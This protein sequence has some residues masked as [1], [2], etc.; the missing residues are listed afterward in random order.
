MT[1]TP[2]VLGLDLDGV[3]AD[4]T[5]GFRSYVAGV[6]G[7]PAEHLPDPVDWDWTRCGW[8]IGSR[9]EYLDLHAGAVDAGLF[10]D[11][12]PLPGVSEALWR[13][14]DAGVRV[15]V[16]TH[17]LI[18]SGSHAASAADTV[19]WL[20]RHRIPYWDLCFM[21]DKPRVGADL[22]VDDSPTNIAAIR[23]AGLPA[24][25]FDQPYNRHLD[26]PRVRDWAEAAD[27]VLSHAAVRL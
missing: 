11:L 16:I 24:L 9:Q 4:Y 1:R 2:F 3:C 13:L 14:S 25:I 18:V 22:Y 6:R 5:A 15:R 17:R 19:L 20:E 10:R 23:A 27:V 7:V 12:E 21:A 26:G 8:G